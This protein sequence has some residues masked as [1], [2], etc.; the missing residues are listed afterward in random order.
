MATRIIRRTFQLKPDILADVETHVDNFAREQ[1]INSCSEKDGYITSIENVTVES[2]D[3][4]ETT[5]FLNVNA[6]SY[7]HLRAHETS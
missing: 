1:V 7:T 3:V 6:V 4:C 2:I 5:S